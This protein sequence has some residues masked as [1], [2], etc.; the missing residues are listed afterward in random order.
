MKTRDTTLDFAK[1]F[2]II[3]V[4]LGHSIQFSLGPDWL[5]S[6][7][8]FDNVVFKTIYSFHMPLFMLISGYL[9]Y[10]SN[11]K[12]LRTLMISKLKAIGIPMLSFVLLYNIGNYL[13]IIINE[14]GG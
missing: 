9:F 2:L 5:E 3:L 7:Q 4:V 8:F 12:N 14:W 1:G 11:K 6:K 10:Y 13:L